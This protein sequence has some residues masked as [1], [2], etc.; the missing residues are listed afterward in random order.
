GATF[1]GVG[2]RCFFLDD[3]AEAVPADFVAGLLAESILER[4]PGEKVIHDVRAS[5]AV[6][7]TVR[8]SG[9]IPV[10]SR[11]GPAFVQHLMR[12]EQAVFGADGSG[13]YSFRELWPGESV[14]A[15]VLL[16]L[17]LVSSSGKRLSELLRPFR[18]R[19]FSI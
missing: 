3:E 15:P 9:G 17:E 19:Y 16:L 8:R 1:D 5:W 10:P 14:V 2:G 6:A 18:E 13:R 4:H 7:E 12:K 11:V